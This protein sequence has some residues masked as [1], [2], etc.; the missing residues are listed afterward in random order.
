MGGKT[1]L[2]Y[3][4]RLLQRAPSRLSGFL[5]L[6]SHREI[7]WANWF[8]YGS[9][10]YFV[11]GND[12]C[13][14]WADSHYDHMGPH[15]MRLHPSPAIVFHYGTVTF[16]TAEMSSLASTSLIHLRFDLFSSW[17]PRGRQKQGKAL[18]Q[19]TPVC[20]SNHTVQL[21]GT[22]TNF[23]AVWG[24]RRIGGLVNIRRPPERW[25]LW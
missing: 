10:S 17:Q 9:P 7:P 16:T 11:H 19:C 15:A 14:A 24:S 4:W 18:T 1:A 25:V 5:W 23:W 13:K 12:T 20:A 2:S 3:L 8:W 22:L 21:S 6:G